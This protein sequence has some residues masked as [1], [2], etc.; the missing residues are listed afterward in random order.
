[1][2]EYAGAQKVATLLVAD[3]DTGRKVEVPDWIL[4]G[5]KLERLGETERR[6]LVERGIDIAGFLA[7]AVK[8]PLN[9]AGIPIYKRLYA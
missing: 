9:P 3:L 7:G 2:K 4:Y 6:S 8:P 5:Q 1:M